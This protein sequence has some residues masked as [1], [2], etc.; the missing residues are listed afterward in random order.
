M[1]RTRM[2]SLLTLPGVFASVL[3][4]LACPACW[5]AYAGLLTSVGAIRRSWRDSLRL[6]K[7]EVGSFKIVGFPHV[8]RSEEIWSEKRL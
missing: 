7:R 8:L 1:N 3:P 2:Q 5:P 6:D 4:N